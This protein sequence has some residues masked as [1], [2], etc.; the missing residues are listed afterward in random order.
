MEIC[1]CKQSL[2]IWGFARTK[3]PTLKVCPH[4]I[5]IVN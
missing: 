1:L 2:A 4:L 3:C 5:R